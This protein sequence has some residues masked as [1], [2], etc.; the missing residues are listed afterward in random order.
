MAA[1][2]AGE[3]RL[4]LSACWDVDIDWAL[5]PKDVKEVNMPIC[6]VC[7]SLPTEWRECL[8]FNWYRPNLACACVVFN[9]SPLTIQ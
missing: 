5:Y 3:T 8:F 4:R 6:S 7:K 2:A 1:S 9:T